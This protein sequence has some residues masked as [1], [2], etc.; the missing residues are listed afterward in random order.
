MLTS[1]NQQHFVINYLFQ[2]LVFL[3]KIGILSIVSES[4]NSKLNIFRLFLFNI[5]SHENIPE[6]TVYLTTY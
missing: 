3:E 5:I 6:L 1:Q 2:A 4:K